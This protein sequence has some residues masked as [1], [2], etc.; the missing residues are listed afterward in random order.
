MRRSRNSEQPSHQVCISCGWYKPLHAFTRDKRAP[1]GRSTLCYKCARKYRS[2]RHNSWH[3]QHRE[4]LRAYHREYHLAHHEEHNARA[5]QR[6][7]QR[8][9]ERVTAY[10]RRAA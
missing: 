5:R 2:E 8:K 6:K 10:A 9:I 7:W 1:W 3:E 4:E